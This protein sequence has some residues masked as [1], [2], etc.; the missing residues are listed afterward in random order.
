MLIVAS[1]RH[2][3]TASA[4]MAEKAGGGVELL[5]VNTKKTIS[6]LI[7]AV[8]MTGVKKARSKPQ[9]RGRIIVIHLPN[10]PLVSNVMRGSVN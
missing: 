10:I 6:G 4:I 1:L 7:N 5:I 8:P 3:T 2:H 9:I